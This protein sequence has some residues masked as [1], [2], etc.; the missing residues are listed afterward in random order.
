MPRR[1]PG[2]LTVLLA[3]DVTAA[4]APRPVLDHLR[5]P[6]ERK[7]RPPVTGMAWLAALLPPRPP[8]TPPLPEPGRIMARRQR[9]VGRVALQPLLELL[10]SDVP[11][12]ARP[13]P[14]LRTA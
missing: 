10:D 2:R 5:H 9:R 13:W 7:Q 8:R 11:C 4:A 3:E 6:L 14:P 12:P 1:L